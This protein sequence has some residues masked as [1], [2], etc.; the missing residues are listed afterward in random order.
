MLDKF[1]IVALLVSVAAAFATPEFPQAQVLCPALLAIAVLAA[2]V[3]TSSFAIARLVRRLRLF[4]LVILVV[5]AVYMTVQLVPIPIH[6]AGNPAAARVA[7][8]PLS[9]TQVGLFDDLRPAPD[10]SSQMSQR[11]DPVNAAAQETLPDFDNSGSFIDDE[12]QYSWPVAMMVV[13][14]LAFAAGGLVVG[15]VLK[16]LQ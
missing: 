11:T 2:A 16:A 1:L 7:V 4:L 15:L 10:Q 6:G 8:P 3:F 5:P 14:P 9:D 12:P 13:A